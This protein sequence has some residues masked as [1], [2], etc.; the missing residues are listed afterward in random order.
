MTSSPPARHA[1][2]PVDPL[3]LERWSPRSFSGEDIPEADLRTIFEAARWAPSSFNSQPWRIFFAR[4]GAPGFDLFLGLLSPL[5]QTWA[6]N[7]SVLAV[8]ASKRLF[9]S[10]SGVARESRSHSFD[11]GAAWGFLALQAHKL[12]YATHAMSGFDAARAAVE[13]NMPEDFRP[14]IALAIGRRGSR[15]A[16]PDDLRAREQPNGRNRQA[17]FVFE[18][19]FPQ[20]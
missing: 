7:A 9:Q 6:R 8:V 20:D 1:E 16:L 11:A 10:A 5:N 4:R 13:L 14:E 12:G 19:A 18:G 15:E 2:H 17:A 3:F